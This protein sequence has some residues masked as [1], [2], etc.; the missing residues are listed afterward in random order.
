ME[1]VPE[2][3]EGKLDPGPLGGRIDIDHVS[4]RYDQRGPLA[5][6]DLSLSVAAGECVALVGPSGCGKSTLLRLLLG[7][8]RPESGAV[9]FDGCDL[10][11][12]DVQAVRRQFG[13]V[14][15][16][17]QLTPGSLLDNILGP[18]LHLGDAEAWAAA[19]RV[20][21]ADDIRAM[22]MGMRTVIS[23]RGGLS[24]GQMQRVLLVRAIVGGPRFLLLDEATSALDNVTQAEVA[25]SLDRLTATRLVIAHRLS[26]VRN[27]DRILALKDGGVAEAGT[28]DVLMARG[29][30]F[31]DMAQRQLA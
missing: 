4:F 17:D 5:L 22:P 12:L 3:D 2:A 16:N 19:E 27:A 31:R 6:R 8:E 24:G 26:T 15:Q 28:Y 21:L 13:V 20:G 7:F 18:N 29:G 23:G 9:L 10:A 14:L 11:T 25:D 1:T 30:L